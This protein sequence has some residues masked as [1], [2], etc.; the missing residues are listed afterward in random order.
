[1]QIISLELSD[2]LLIAVPDGML[3]ADKT[4]S[5]EISN[6]FAVNL[7]RKIYLK[8]NVSLNFISPRVGLKYFAK[9][10]VSRLNGLWSNQEGP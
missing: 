9:N 8:L 7:R 5:Q 3:T 1:M 2:I 4:R 10:G 6:Q